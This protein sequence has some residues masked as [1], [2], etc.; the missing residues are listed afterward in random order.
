MNIDELNRKY[1]APGRIVFK[2]GHC[3]RPEAALANKYGSAEV[4]LAG[5]V[6]LSYRPTG[7][8]PVIFRPERRDYA[9]GEKI[10]GGIPICWPQFSKGAIEGMCPHGFAQFMTF[11]VRGSRYGE[12]S[13]EL[14]LGLSS[15]D[16]TRSAWPHE[17]DLELRV[18]LSMKL[19][20]FLKT[21]N[22]GN[23]P[24]GFTAAFH[25]YF[26]VRDVE[27][28]A[29]KGL[30]G[31]DYTDGR[32]MSR[33]RQSGDFSA[34]GGCDHIFELAPAPKH[35]AAILDSG[36]K[37]AIAVASSG[38]GVFTVWNPNKASVMSDHTADDWKSFLC[39]EPCTAWRRPLT[40]LKPGE[41]AE[42]AMAIQSVMES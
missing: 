27:K 1:G 31:C 16:E 38:N 6:V 18:V 26:L 7:S 19:N 20:L 36:L 30:D 9:L 41:S 39:V 33:A 40:E 28:V 25:P 37:R 32:D 13:T 3:A 12:E 14:T 34:A 35:E 23:A 17:F 11:E 5:G 8:H 42:L 10:H 22:T 29:V 4:A 21:T 2:A 24:F 15:S